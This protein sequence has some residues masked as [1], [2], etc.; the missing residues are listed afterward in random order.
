MFRYPDIAP[1]RDDR[2][3]GLK[4][5][6]ILVL[7]SSLLTGLWLFLELRHLR[8]RHAATRDLV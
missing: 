7:G 5:H 3:W 8:R 4:G 6:A 1:S 2:F